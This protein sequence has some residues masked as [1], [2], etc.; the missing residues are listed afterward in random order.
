MGL[1]PT[2]VFETDQPDDA[3]RNAARFERLWE[4]EKRKCKEANEDRDRNSD[5]VKPSLSK[6]VWQFG[7]TRF[8]I[9]IFLVTL[10]MFFQFVGP[11]QVVILCS[12]LTSYF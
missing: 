2:D 6:V 8:L 9:T 12:L 3:I 7:K 5:Q 1:V 4:A 11:V 10:S